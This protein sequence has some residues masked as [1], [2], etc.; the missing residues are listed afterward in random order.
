MVLIEDAELRNLRYVFE[1]REHG[2]KLLAEKLKKYAGKNTVVLAIPSGG[3]PIGK[4]IAEKLNSK[5]DLVIT[6]KVQL[7]DNPE[8]GFG[9][10]SF[11]GEVVVN[12]EWARELSLT[13]E[14]INFQIEKARKEV[15]HRVNKFRGKRLFPS[16]K[17][18]IVIIA[19]DGL[20]T[21]YTMLAAIKSIK[22]LEPKKLIVAVPTASRGAISLVER[23]VDEIYCLNVRESF[24]FAVADAYQEWHDMSENEVLSYLRNKT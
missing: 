11:D 24:V 14:I 8:A 12:L 6:R 18:K 23:E 3:V 13:D 4:I 1:N 10:V 16:L 22:K 21:G 2:G 5:F 19:D 15:G 9:A 7:P 17:G 20:A